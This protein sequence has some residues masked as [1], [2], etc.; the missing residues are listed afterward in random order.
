MQGGP[1]GRTGEPYEVVVLGGGNAALC[2]AMSA[3]DSGARVLVL[4]SAPPA[5]RGG[6]SRHTRNLRYLH[7]EPTRYLTGPYSEEEFWEDLVRVTKGNTDEQLARLTLRASRDVGRWMERHGCRFQPSLR[8][9]LQL[10][11]TNA[12]FRGGGKALLNA[13]C[14]TAERSGV[15]FEY[16]AEVTD[17]VFDEGPLVSVRLGEQREIRAKAVVAASGGYQANRAWLAES[18]GPAAEN[19]IVR[20]TAFDTGLVTRALLARGVR[21]VGDATQCHA[22][23][24]D[25]R[26]P[27]HDGG[28]VTRLD[29]IPFGIVV[30]RG[31]ERFYDEGEDL[32]PK[33]YA[34]WGRLIAQQPGQV[35]WSIVDAR[36]EGRFMPSVFPPLEGASISEL[37]DRIGLDSTRL[38]ATVRRYNDAVRP[39]RYDPT[40]LDDCSTEDLEPA[41]SHWALPIDQPPFRA[42][43]LRPGIT[44]TYMGVAVDEQARV[45][46]DDG[47]AQPNIFAAGEIMAGNVLGEGYLAGLGMTIGTVFGRIAGEGAARVALG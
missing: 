6:N 21:S 29:T 35:A 41:K 14:Q 4:E 10:S 30:D 9:A 34:I 11:R 25:A 46:L 15:E 3:A 37:A 39:G 36:V 13:Y 27:E 42:Y 16:D 19:F 47:R 8:G 7:D 32:W 28:I 20:G 26:A 38:Q 44:F 45:R 1:R 33:R 22:I 23:A 43:P 18:W 17:V 40:S 31:A 12:F 2:A 24:V 5:L